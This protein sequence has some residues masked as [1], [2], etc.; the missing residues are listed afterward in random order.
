VSNHGL[1]LAVDDARG[2]AGR[3]EEL[4]GEEPTEAVP[5][6]TRAGPTRPWCTHT[7]AGPQ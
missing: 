5:I 3:G 1:D 4:S 2:E 6:G 7:R